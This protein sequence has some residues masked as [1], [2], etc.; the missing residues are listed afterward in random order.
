MQ[1]AREGVTSAVGIDL[2][3]K[4][5]ETARRL[6]AEEGLSDKAIF[7]V[8]DGARTQLRTSD[9]VILDAV[10]C[11]YP[12][13]AELVKNSSSAARVYYAVSFPDNRRLATKLL[14]VLLPLQG[15]IFRR[16]TFRFF[17]HPRREVVA[18]RE[19]KGFTRISESPVGWMWSVILFAAPASA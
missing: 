19:K 3:P 17:I 14:R 7:E 9:V 15:M 4:M 10:L 18:I 6:A 2:S 13:A 11:C 5:V 16:G 12:D 8:G 1:L